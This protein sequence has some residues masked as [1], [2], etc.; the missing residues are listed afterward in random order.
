MCGI[1]GFW[2]PANQHVPPGTL[3]RMNDALLRRGPDGEGLFEEGGV[4]LAMRRLSIIDLTGG[5]QPIYNEDR[6]VVVVMNGEIYNYQRL[7]RTLKERGHRF[8]TASDTEVLVH[9]YEEHGDAL[10]DHLEGMFAFALWDIRR[11]R[12]LVARDRLGI[13]PLYFTFQGGALLF[14]SEIKALKASGKVRLD[15]DPVALDD[16]FTYNF[17]PAPRSIYRDIRKLKPG[18]RMTIEANGELAIDAYW[19][20][21]REPAQKLPNDASTIEVIE[22]ALRDAVESHLVADV[23]VGSFLSGG[24]DSGL[25]TAFAAR[26]SG[27]PISTYTI[28]FASS[29]NA[30]LDERV[31][32]RELASRYG[33]THHEFEITPDVAAIFNEIVCAFDEPF[34]DDSVIP[35][36]YVSQ[37][38]ARELKVALTGL[39]GDELF[40]GYRRHA[41]IRLDEKLGAAASFTRAALALP[42]RLIPEML[43]RS[44]AIDHVKRFVRGGGSRAERYAQFMSALPVAQRHALYSDRVRS[45]LLEAG[46]PANLIRTCYEELPSGSA[47]RRALHA[48]AAVYLPDDVLTLT[49]R[50]SMWHSLELR[51]PFLDRNLV[52]L[53]ARLPDTLWIDGKHQ[54][55]VLRDIAGRWLP[56]S[57]L[58]HRKQGFEAPM[59]AW[60]RGPLLPFFD[61]RV[62][63]RTVTDSGLL[64]WPT[65]KALRDEHVAGRHKHSKTLFAALML[66]GWAQQPTGA[67]AGNA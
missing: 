28:G 52:E 7:A 61:A 11:R 54:K 58:T 5:W 30:F 32:A 57:I 64:H 33:C 2:L 21:P 49:D 41:G 66:M 16:L 24:V 22:G 3:K 39:G 1:A 26:I 45:D 62:N 8:S 13:K 51:V 23:P 53:A 67:A 46:E 40:G 38:A 15:I 44:D 47:L 19:S 65:I 10:V 60:L 42:V 35:S 48:D 37:F 43:A 20:L 34:A 27:K 25:I 29:G 9:L 4:G 50:L 59:G 36:Y 31:Y 14:A 63:E 56:A 6:S 55:A 18:H 17:I 12:L